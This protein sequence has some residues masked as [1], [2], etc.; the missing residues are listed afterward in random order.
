MRIPTSGQR[1]FPS[2]RQLVRASGE[3]GEARHGKIGLSGSVLAHQLA[4]AREFS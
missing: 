4:G 3:A 1:I 2:A